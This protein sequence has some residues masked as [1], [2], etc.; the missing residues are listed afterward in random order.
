MMIER[1]RNHLRDLRLPERAADLVKKFELAC[2]AI[3]ERPV[4]A[5]PALPALRDRLRGI[6]L[7]ANLLVCGFVLG[8][9]VWSTFAP[10]ESAAIA[11]G[12]VE[13]EVEPKDNPAP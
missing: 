6:T 1:A 7:T 3:A 5:G 11:F 9:G 8:L 13:S 4:C 12:T 2:V 10:L